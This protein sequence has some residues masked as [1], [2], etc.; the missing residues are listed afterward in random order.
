MRGQRLFNEIIKES[1]IERTLRKGRNNSLIFKRNECLVAR[2]YFY[3]TFKNKCYEE[4]LRLLI[5]EFFISPNT[6][7]LIIQNNS[8]QLQALKQRSPVFHYFMNRWP[9]LKW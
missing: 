8:E 6:I 7:V 3:A 1:G 4:I 2:Y 5:S 9:H